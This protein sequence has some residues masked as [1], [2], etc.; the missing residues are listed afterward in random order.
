MDAHT[1]ERG[2]DLEDRERR[3]D[4]EGRPPKGTGLDTWKPNANPDRKDGD[5]PEH[6]YVEQPRSAHATCIGRQRKILEQ[7]A[8]HLA[9]IELT[10]GERAISPPRYARC[11]GVVRPPTRGHDSP[12]PARALLVAADSETQRK[13]AASKRAAC[14]RYVCRLSGCASSRETVCPNPASLGDH[15][16]VRGGADARAGR[17]VHAADSSWLVRGRPVRQR[18]VYALPPRGWTLTSRA[19]TM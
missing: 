1:D 10:L 12:S 14:R 8:F 19:S 15:I 5:A 3:S 6:P 2:H 18:S 4:V 17:L 11:C 16:L 9:E 13:Q 7:K